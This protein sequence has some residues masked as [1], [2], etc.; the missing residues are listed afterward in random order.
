MTGPV[1]LLLLDRRDLARRQRDGVVKVVVRESEG[2]D[3]A[4]S[5]RRVRTERIV[6]EHNCG[7]QRFL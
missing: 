4:D 2:T 5:A 1:V 7:R 6:T 3:G